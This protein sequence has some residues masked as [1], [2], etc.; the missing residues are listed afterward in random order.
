M[1]V[2]RRLTLLLLRRKS[3]SKKGSRCCR[4]AKFLAAVLHDR[5]SRLWF[6]CNRLDFNEQ[7]GK[8]QTSNNN[9][10][11]GWRIVPK[12]IAACFEH[13]H[14]F[15]GVGNIGIDFDDVLHLGSGG[16]QDC[17]D[18]PKHLARLGFDISFANQF[19]VG[20]EGDLPG[21]INRIADLLGLG[22]R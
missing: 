1:P 10:G 16:C 9:S 15:V 8:S 14:E 18:V 13:V 3:Q 5:L 20:I 11:A 7:A 12:D 17:L 6:Y 21:H 4:V 2:R 22:Q 19:A